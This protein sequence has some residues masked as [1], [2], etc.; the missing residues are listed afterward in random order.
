MGTPL[1]NEYLYTLNVFP[2]N[3][4]TNVMTDTSNTHGKHGLFVTPWSYYILD[5]ICMQTW[6]T[7]KTNIIILIHVLSKCGPSIKSNLTIYL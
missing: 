5:L 2:D 1:D 6:V 3:A 4:I 7:Y